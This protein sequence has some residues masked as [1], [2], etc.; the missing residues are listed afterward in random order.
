M[1][2]GGIPAHNV[3]MRKDW[4]RLVLV[5]V[6]QLLMAIGLAV[7]FHIKDGLAD[8]EDVLWLTVLAIAIAQ[9]VLTFMLAILAQAATALRFSLTA[10][11]VLV[12]YCAGELIGTQWMVIV[13]VAGAAASGLA[14]AL[15]LSGVVIA[16]TGGTYDQYRRHFSILDLIELITWCGVFAGGIRLAMPGGWLFGWAVRQDELAVIT[17]YAALCCITCWGCLAKNSLLFR[18]VLV[19]VAWLATVVCDIVLDSGAY[20]TSLLYLVTSEVFFVAT[21]A[22]PLRMLGYQLM[23]PSRASAA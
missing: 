3:G 7:C 21:A 8:L 6:T 17:L 20:S 1:A 5:A 4:L 13:L 12:W 19:F 23:R 18:S 16:R 14:W 15:R 2:L 10:V 22:V 11:A 9:P